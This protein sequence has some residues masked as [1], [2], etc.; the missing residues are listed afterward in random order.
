MTRGVDEEL[1]AVFDRK[2]QRIGTKTREQ[3]H[4]DGD[5]HWLVFVWVAWIRADGS[6]RFLL[7]LRGRKGDPHR[8]QLDAFAGGH[9]EAGE[10]HL[11][12]AIRECYEESGIKISG[13]NLVL[14][15]TRSMENPSG[16]RVRCRVSHELDFADNC[17][18][19]PTS[20]GSIR[21]RA[22]HPDL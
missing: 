7:Q 10:S 2:G 17:S 15:G 8:G 21:R 3:A 22:W 16:H 18:C 19:A 1:V 11:E 4:R 5:W 13:D 20:T 14:L 6:K 9:V 12:G